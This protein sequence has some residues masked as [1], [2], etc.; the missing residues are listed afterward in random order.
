MSS[1]KMLTYDFLGWEYPKSLSL[2]VLN[3]SLDPIFPSLYRSA[4]YVVFADGG[5]NRVYDEYGSKAKEF[6]PDCVIGDLDSLRPEVRKFYE[7][8]KVS[9]FRIEEQKSSDAI[10][11]LR[12][13]AYKSSPS[14]FGHLTFLEYY[15]FL[16]KEE[17]KRSPVETEVEIRKPRNDQLAANAKIVVLYNAFG[18]RF[19]QQLGLLGCLLRA[20]IRIKSDVEFRMILL[21]EDNLAECLRSGQHLLRLHSIFNFNRRQI[22]S[23]QN[24]GTEHVATECHCGFM[25]YGDEHQAITTRGLRWDMA[26]TRLSY[27]HTISACNIIDEKEVFVDTQGDVLFTIELLPSI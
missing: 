18:G 10:K 13:I 15:E 27:Y 2:I 22:L 20:N 11:A 19:D 16:T 25:P 23:S 4:E 24:E 9:V 26:S 3:N 17:L 14:S 12:F 21:S 7:E 5:A 8:N 1:E 6:L